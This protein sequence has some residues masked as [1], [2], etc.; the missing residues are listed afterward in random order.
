MLGARVIS[1][2]N[3]QENAGDEQQQQTAETG[4][5]ANN[6]HNYGSPSQ[7]AAMIEPDNDPTEYSDHDAP[8]DLI[9]P[10]N[11][12][13][14]DDAF[15]TSSS[16]SDASEG[17][18]SQNLVDVDMEDVFAY[19]GSPT[20]LAGV[21]SG[22]YL[23]QHP[24]THYQQ[25][26]QP[27]QQRLQRMDSTPSDDSGSGR[28]ATTTSQ[29]SSRDWGWFEDNASGKSKKSIPHR[30]GLDPNNETA[31]AAMAVTA[32]TYVL[33]ESLSSQRLWKYTAGNR[34]PQPMEERMFYE[35]M[36]AQNFARSQVNY[37][38]PSMCSRP[39]RPF[40][41][42]PLLEGTM[43]MSAAAAADGGDYNQY[44]ISLFSP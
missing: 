14:S 41:S 16:L 39:R 27:K 26:L 6:S 25:H 10:P 29:N 7:P 5:N 44:T 40:P 33:E 35:K 43:E 32:P 34:P 42:A 31:A 23:N 2:Q 15:T 11:R 17:N 12:N 9:S 8:L 1:D 36:W 13:V 38:C 21:G 3:V 28:G 30:I 4:D 22:P 24:P 19:E 37:K 20:P 18:K